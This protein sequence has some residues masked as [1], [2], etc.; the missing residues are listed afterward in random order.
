MDTLS[1]IRGTTKNIVVSV[2][3]E[4]GNAATLNAEDTIVFGV[5]EEYGMYEYAIRKTAYGSEAVDGQITFTI[6]PIDTIGLDV[7]R[8]YYDVGLK[9][10]DK[11]T[12]LV[13][14][15]VFELT[16]NITSSLS[17]D[18]EIRPDKFIITNADKSEIISEVVTIVLSTIESEGGGAVINDYVTPEMFGAI[19]NGVY[20]DGPALTKALMTGRQVKLT[21]DI[22]IFSD[23]VTDGVDV[24]LD[25]NNHTIY[26][27]YAGITI[28]SPQWKP[29]ERSEV[30]IAS[31]VTGK[32]PIGDYHGTTEYHWG[33]MTLNGEKTIHVDVGEDPSIIYWNPNKPTLR[34]FTMQCSNMGYPHGNAKMAL[35]VKRQAFGLI[36]NVR[37]ICRDGDDGADGICVEFCQHF[38]ISKCY[39]RGWTNHLCQTPGGRGYGITAL[40][41]DIKVINCTAEN[42]KH[43]LC[44]GGSAKMTWSSDIL[45]EGCTFR[46][47][48]VNNPTVSRGGS[49]YMQAIDAH[50]DT[51]SII[52]SNCN[53]YIYDPESPYGIWAMNIRCPNVEVYNVNISG[54]GGNITFGEMANKVHLTNVFAPNCVL[55]LDESDYSDTS[56]SFQLDDL[57]IDGCTF[58][59]FE[60]CTVPTRIHMSHSTV[61]TLIRDVQFLYADGCYFPHNIKWFSMPV[62][63]VLGEAKFSNCIIRGNDNM[64]PGTPIIDAPEDSIIMNDCILYTRTSEGYMIFNNDQQN[65]SNNIDRDIMAL[66]LDCNESNLLDVNRLI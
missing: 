29:G 60:R 42:C 41:H 9:S 23:V 2:I 17:A 66:Y 22:Y 65:V 55:R 35:Y 56:T 3:D 16:A 24:Q 45:I 53:V 64:S 57:W 33:Y 20:D 11:F 6:N 27:D 12:M 54:N 46:Q 18:P 4:K 30:G 40:G 36:E 58:S 38:T 8:Y 39:S 49:V 1:M 26:C 34:N 31:C 52:V 59:S 10:G 47:Y 62:I 5:K 15:N 7:G 19:G 63:K 25:G 43:C 61:L 51:F 13:S 28:L 48:A 37:T 21:K 44:S 50:A 14:M 32:D